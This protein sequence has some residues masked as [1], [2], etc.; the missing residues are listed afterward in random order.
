MIKVTCPHCGKNLRAQDN[1]LGKKSSC[2][3]C[4]KV[5][6]IIPDIELAEDTSPNI[7]N[8][9][10]Q[11]SPHVN[12]NYVS[13]LNQMYCS[14]CGNAILKQAV[15]C[16]LC[17]CSTGNNET[18]PSIVPVVL[19]YIFAVLIPI[20]GLIIGF[21]FCCTQNYKNRGSR[22]MIASFI[23]MFVYFFLYLFLCSRIIY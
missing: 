1:S 16:P 3:S 22:I 9:L 12:S 20:I 11:S 13:P 14:H 18:R 2:P 21:I 17:G 4:N 5:V 10:M 15:F 8:L 19:G 6:E 23:V 7:D